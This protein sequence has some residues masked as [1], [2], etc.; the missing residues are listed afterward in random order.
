M[1]D[2]LK[3]HVFLD[4]AEPNHPIDA[5][6]LEFYMDSHGQTEFLN[7]PPEYVAGFFSRLLKIKGIL[8][9]SNILLFNKSNLV[10]PFLTLEGAPPCFSAAT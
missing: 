8:P 9:S 7:L 2:A 5:Y 10:T 1:A 6:H 3:N 4:H